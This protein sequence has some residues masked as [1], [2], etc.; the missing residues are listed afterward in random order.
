MKHLLL[1][2]IGLAIMFGAGRAAPVEYEVGSGLIYVRVH[3]LPSD[4]PP[5]PSGKAPPCIVDV[6]YVDAD[7]DAA[8]AFLAWLK[9]RALPRSPVFVLANAETSSVLIRM[10][11]AHE[12]GTGLAVVGIAKG[13]F[14]PDVPVKATMD[15][16]RRAYDALERGANI[17]IL[18]A[19]NPN[20]A[21]NDEASLSK[22][23]L[24]E[25]SA[26]A[27]DGKRESPP[28]DA[29]LQRAVH[30]HRALVALKRI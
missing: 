4:L 12:R 11:N 5:K 10:L 8:T 13:A 2:L 17:G 23:R 22:D 29:T 16:E 15:E 30:L 7:A 3:Q 26:D 28:I 20:K 24:A 27:A 6:R 9:F 19:D 1:A 25:A 21:R 14:H 18:L